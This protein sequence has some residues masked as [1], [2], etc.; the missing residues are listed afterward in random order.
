M[1]RSRNWHDLRSPISKIRKIQIVDTYVLTVHCEFQ[2]VRITGVPLERCQTSKNTTWSGHLMWPGGVIFGVI[3]S[4]FFGSVPNCWLN[5][6]GKF[7]GATRR[8]FSISAK[9]LRGRKTAPGRARDN[10]TYKFTHSEGPDDIGG[11][12]YSTVGVETPIEAGGHPYQINRTPM[13]NL[14]HPQHPYAFLERIRHFSSKHYH[15][16]NLHA[17]GKLDGCDG[18]CKKNFMFVVDRAFA[19]DRMKKVKNSNI[20]SKMTTVSRVPILDGGGKVAAPPPPPPVWCLTKVNGIILVSSHV[21]W[22]EQICGEISNSASRNFIWNVNVKK[23]STNF[24]RYRTGAVGAAT[25]PH[26]PIYPIPP[27]RT[28]VIADAE[29]DSPVT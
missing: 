15:E 6:Y 25:L 19:H 23:N 14:G 2:R 1:G 27:Y 11:E 12:L 28:L 16:N 17:I 8:R 26:L 13:A 7:G 4:S 9:N 18:H 22:L 29:A 10:I 5:S 21:I 3:G 20:K 24:V